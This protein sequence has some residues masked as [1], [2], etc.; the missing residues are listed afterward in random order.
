MSEYWKPIE[1]LNLPLDDNRI[2]CAEFT[3]NVL[4]Q[5]KA[6]EIDSPLEAQ[7]FIYGLKY[8]IEELKAWESDFEDSAMDA[9]AA[10]IY[11]KI[12]ELGESGAG[13]NPQKRI[14]YL[15]GLLEDMG[16]HPYSAITWTIE[17]GIIKPLDAEWRTK[18]FNFKN[19]YEEA[20]YEVALG[21][22]TELWLSDGTPDKNWRVKVT[23]LDW[24]EDGE[25]MLYLEVED[26]PGTLCLT[27]MGEDYHEYR[28]T[29]EVG[30]M[31]KSGRKCVLS[32]LTTV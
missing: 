14:N 25:V 2:G 31:D 13:G 32:D 22:D 9:T 15:N 26:I 21:I 27:M 12:H 3:N 7:N 4:T 17:G 20:M 30:F 6:Q 23:D 18:D 24:D 29:G 19:V 10:E 28:R 1:P 8:L 16:Y 11:I 5:L